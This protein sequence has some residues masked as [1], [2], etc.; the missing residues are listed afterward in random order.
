MASVTP[1]PGRFA[2][3]FTLLLV[4]FALLLCKSIALA[5]LGPDGIAMIVNSNE[6]MGREL[7]QVYAA[8]RHIPDNRILELSLPKTEEMPFKQYEEEVVPQVREFLRT[9]H[10]EDEVKCFVTFYGVPIRIAARVPTAA[11]ADELSRIRITINQSVEQV[12]KPV[13]DL[14]KLATQLD[15]SYTPPAG[16]NGDFEQLFERAG[17]AVQIIKAQLGTIPDPRRRAAVTAQMFQTVEP[18]IGLSAKAQRMAIE[19]VVNPASQPTTQRAAVEAVVTEYRQ[20]METAAQ[21]EQRRYDAKSRDQ[22]RHIVKTKFGLFSWIKLLRDQADYLDPRD[23]TAAFDNELAM[24]RWAMYQ[25]VRWRDNPLF[26]AAKRQ[27]GGSAPTLMVMRLDAPKPEEV[28]RIITD[29]IQAETAG[30][31]GKAVLDSR[32]LNVDTAKPSERGLVE[33]D[34]SIR[35]LANRIRKH[36]KMEVLADDNPDV[37]PPNSADDV[38]LYC[39]WYS[40]RHYIPECKFNHG[41]VGW[42]IASYEMLS[43]H[44][45]GEGGW[46]PG[47]INDGVDATLG[48]VAEPYVQMF[49][50]P[51]EFFSLLLTGKLTL[52]EV[53]WRTTPAVSWMI[54]AIGDPLYTPFKNNP[55]LT[56]QDLPDR[57]KAAMTAP[58]PASPA[59]P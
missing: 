9:G 59:E 37:L 28:R 15:Q 19:A 55:Q 49:P 25:R 20:G 6:P 29:S 21:L 54:S 36:S 26:Y 12:V 13:L 14:E 42:H 52:A 17:R 1:R 2:S 50:K 4:G 10:L 11:E 5:E 32:G 51:D 44:N 45:E 53:Y 48:P 40:V 43:L 7:A 24:V 8:A 46:V 57:L 34:Q 47:L 39:G 16:S 3:S 27:V 38:A 22:L 18:L 30:L 41:A 23:T 33:Y 58:A 31:K 56:E 35:D